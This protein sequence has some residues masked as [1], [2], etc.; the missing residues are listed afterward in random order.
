[1]Q[2]KKALYYDGHDRPDVVDYR[3][4]V[5]LPQMVEYRKRLVSYKV[6]DV[7]TPN[8]PQNYVER[9]LVLLPQ[10]E[11]T[12]RK[13]ND[14]PKASWVPN[15]EQPLKKK[16]AGRGLHESGVICS[17]VGYMPDANQTIEYG[18]NYDGYWTG[19]LFVEQVCR[20]LFDISLYLL[21]MSMLCMQLAN[22]I[23]P[24]FKKVHGPGYQ[25]LIMVTTTLLRDM[26]LIHQML[27]KFRK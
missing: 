17:T 3:Q 26:Q 24:T 10:D 13:S 21:L 12:M 15:G 6:G 23:I 16:G 2:H 9:G 19:Q 20:L 4:N 22:K 27:F 1:M 5:F 14:G 11:S 25:A 18:K 8:P 7:E